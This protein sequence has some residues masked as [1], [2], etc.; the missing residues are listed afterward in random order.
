MMA[1]PEPPAIGPPLP[2]QDDVC[3]YTPGTI[4]D[5]GEMCKTPPSMHILGRTLADDPDAGWVSV[6]MCVMHVN[7]A[8]SAMGVVVERH[9]K[10]PDCPT[11][12]VT[13]DEFIMAGCLTLSAAYPPETGDP[14]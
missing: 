4:T 1:A 8:I 14:E 2:G 10:R 6:L 12:S 13:L 3:C 5:P 11:G 9:W 7:A